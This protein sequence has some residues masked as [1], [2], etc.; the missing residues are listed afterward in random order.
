MVAAIHDIA[1]VRWQF[2]P[3]GSTPVITA[4]GVA[5]FHVRRIRRTEIN[6]FRIGHKYTRGERCGY[7]KH[8]L[9]L[10]I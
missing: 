5:L 1:W 7:L 4:M 3:R 10:A 8:V 6:M 9:V 2:G